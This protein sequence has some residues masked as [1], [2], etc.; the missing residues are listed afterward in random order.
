M[1]GATFEEVWI[2]T[3][4]PTADLALLQIDLSHPTDGDPVDVEPV[5][6]GDSDKIVVG[7]EAIS[8]GNPLGLAHT[9]TTGI[10]SSRRTYRGKQWIQMSTPISPGN[11]GGPVF[12]AYGEVIGVS[13]ASVGG[14]FGGGQNLNLAVPINVL[15]SKIRPDY[16][17]K[18]K[19]GT[20]GGA[21]TW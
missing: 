14:G 1:K 4:D 8:I 17:G 11:S 10:V 21:S 7:E 13:T 3:A 6:L 18:R 19:F 12:N 16:P 2:L 15:K 9:M 5:V 20:A